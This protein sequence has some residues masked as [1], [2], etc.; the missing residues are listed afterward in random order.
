MNW[1]MSRIW[2]YIAM[3]LG[4]LALLGGVYRRGSTSKEREI[5][6]EDFSRDKDGRDA[7]A[8]EQTETDGL[9]SS[10]LV[11]RMRSRDGDWRG[12]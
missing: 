2:P 7:V 10:E 8:K 4:G 5:I 1:V 12:L 11:D 6:A 9:S 3:L